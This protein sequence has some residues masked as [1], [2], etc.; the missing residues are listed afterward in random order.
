MLSLTDIKGR[1]KD[2]EFENGHGLSPIYIN[3]IIV[4]VYFTK[5]RNK[6]YGEYDDFHEQSQFLFKILPVLR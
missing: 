6:F 1:T 3:Y 5:I 2:T 4:H